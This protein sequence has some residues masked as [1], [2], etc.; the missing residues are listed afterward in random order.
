MSPAG[1]VD[2]EGEVNQNEQNGDSFLLQV[3]VVV[4]EIL[5]PRTLRQLSYYATA[6]NRAVSAYLASDAAGE[7]ARARGHAQVVACLGRSY[8]LAAED[9]GAAKVGAILLLSLSIR[10]TE[11]T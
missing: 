2:V 3:R 8:A 9:L 1:P 7:A 4:A 5:G 11:A 10:D 6:L